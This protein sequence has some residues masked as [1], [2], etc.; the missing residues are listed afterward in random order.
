M[1]FCRGA[2]LDVENTGRSDMQFSLSSRIRK[3]LTP[4]SI[5]DR[6]QPS[7]EPK[8]YCPLERCI[9]PRSFFSFA[10]LAIFGHKFPLDLRITNALA[11]S[12][13][14]MCQPTTPKNGFRSYC[15][16]QNY[17]GKV[18]HI[19]KSLRICS[20]SHPRA[21]EPSAPGSRSCCKR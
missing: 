11:S 19:C 1:K 6:N 5:G 18:R 12:P 4:S 16:P 17:V 8:S 7:L 14:A 20:A 10:I 9:Y 15:R 3:A 13:G 21:C 2:A